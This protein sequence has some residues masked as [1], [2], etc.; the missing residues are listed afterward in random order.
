MHV[1]KRRGSSKLVVPMPGYK[2]LALDLFSGK[3]SVGAQ[4]KANGFDVISLD[5]QPS[6]KADIAID[7]LLWD[8]KKAYNP[9]DFAVIAAGVPCT[10]YS[11]ARTTGAPRDL[12]A[13]DLVVAKTLE[14]IAYFRPKR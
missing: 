8:Y 6:S 4:L 12:E 5:C 7:G 1:V 13:A 11:V 3:G 10:Q 9:G 14:I 2:S